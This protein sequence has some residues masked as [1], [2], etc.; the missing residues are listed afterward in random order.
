MR[1]IF[2]VGPRGSGKS[3]VAELLAS[4][5]SLPARDT[6]SLAEEAAGMSVAELV[7]ARGWPAFRELERAALAEA[8]ALGGIIATGGGAVLLPENRDLMRGQGRVFYLCAPLRLLCARL[9]R[10]PRPD[11]RPALTDLAPAAELAAVLAE[12]A[13]LYKA[14]A[15]YIIDAG[16]PLPWVAE[17]IARRTRNLCLEKTV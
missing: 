17:T 11:L 3:S 6:D 2:L 1:S 8:A 13:P 14:A 12:R 16:R 9:A 5:L 4:R 10:N 7:T 15:H